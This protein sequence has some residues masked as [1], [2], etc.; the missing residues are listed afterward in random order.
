MQRGTVHDAC[1]LKSCRMV[2]RRKGKRVRLADQYANHETLVRCQNKRFRKMNE[3]IGV[4]SFEG[5]EQFARM[6]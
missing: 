1:H 6:N 3:L 4:A 2:W 5:S